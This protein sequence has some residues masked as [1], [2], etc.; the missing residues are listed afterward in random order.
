V[1]QRVVLFG[2]RDP[3]TGPGP[4]NYYHYFGDLWEWDGA[5]WSQRVLANAPTPREAAA[6]VFDRARQQLLVLSGTRQEY[7]AATLTFSDLWA[8]DST[9]PANVTTLGPGCGGANGAPAFVPSAPHPGAPAFTLD[10]LCQQANAPCVFLFALANASAALGA[11]CTLFAPAPDLISFTLTGTNGQATMHTA[12]LLGLQGLSF[13]VQA[14]VLDAT[15]PL[16]FATTP[17][18]RIVVGR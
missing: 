4:A 10:L 17:G 2:G 14:A 8:L 11:G 15:S 6:V 9:S 1:R 7:N 3:Q 5:T 18:L 12:I 16:G 13:S